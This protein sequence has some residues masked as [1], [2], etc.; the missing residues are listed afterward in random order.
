ML[1]Q[2][3][4][5][6]WTLCEIMEVGYGDPFRAVFNPRWPIPRD[7]VVPPQVRY[8]WTLLA[9]TPVPPSEK[10][11]TGS[12]TTLAATMSPGRS[13]QNVTP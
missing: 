6:F 4:A 10:G 5:N 12:G 3:D 13:A 1:Q 9:P 7:P 8:D 11:M 2:L